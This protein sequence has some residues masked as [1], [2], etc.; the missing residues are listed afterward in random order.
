MK[1]EI[2]LIGGGGHCR[3]VIEVIESE[4]EFSVAGIVDVPE[5]IGHDI[6]GYKITATDRDIPDLLKKYKY[7]IITVGQIKSSVSRKKIFDNL[8]FEGALLPVIKASTAYLSQHAAVSDG[9]MLMHNSFVNAGVT[10]GK[11]CI[12]NT[13]CTIEHDA[14]IG[15]HCHL[16]TGSFIN[17]ECMIGDAVF[18]GSTAIVN[19]GIKLASGVIIGSGAVVIHDIHESGTYAGNPAKRIN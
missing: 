2:I 18:I 1:K 11:N 16:S 9:T 12:I 13:G 14:R 5:K 10:I 8:I 15:D 4:G 3:S 19:Q 17:G 6:L 7:F